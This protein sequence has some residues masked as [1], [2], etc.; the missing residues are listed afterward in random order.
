[1]LRSMAVETATATRA[2]PIAAPRV[3][4]GWML[5]GITAL[6]AVVRFATLNSQSLWYDETQTVSLVKRGLGDMLRT[7]PDQEITPHLY[8]VVAWGWTHVFGTGPVGIRSLSALLGT[9]TVLVVYAAARELSTERVALVAAALAA[10]NPM[11]VWYSQEARS[12]PLLIFLIALGLWA[13]ARILRRPTEG[14]FVGWALAS[15]LALITHYFAFFAIA[16]E[17]AYLLVRGPARRMT[18]VALTGIGV[19]GLAI[20]PVEQKQYGRHDAEVLT[21]GQS[22]GDRLVDVLKQFLLGP[23][24]HTAF[25]GAELI[26]GGLVAVGLVLLV[27]RARGREASGAWVA[28]LVTAGIA[29]LAIALSL[30]GPDYLI[31]RNLVVALIPAIVLVACGFG[32]RRA[33][34]LGLGALGALCAL[35]LVVLVRVAAEP[36]LQREDWRGAARALTPAPVSR[37]VVV[38]PAASSTISYYM[39]KAKT[40]PWGSPPVRVQEIAFLVVGE[41]P[42]VTPTTSPYF[43]FRLVERRQEPTYTLIRLRSDVPRVVPTVAL[44]AANLRADA[45]GTLI[46]LQ[47]PGG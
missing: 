36:R 33:G 23:G 42:A 22:L 28:G 35:S 30:G 20:L 9:L 29:G 6:A 14:N 11:L 1:M 18:I 43:G 40:T 47:R 4:A 8:D 25:Q 24:G 12:Y 37:A 31:P 16:A 45:G 19:V 10:V 44:G 3:S 21:V 27:A 5:A 7:V 2:V 39:P 15:A 13:F 46:V 26:A 38:N 32:S 41:P 17:A 34:W